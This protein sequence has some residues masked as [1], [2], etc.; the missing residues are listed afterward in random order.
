MHKKIQIHND[1]AC[2]R[3]R[4][5]RSSYVFRRP[6]R[7][8][9][10]S[11][12]SFVVRPSSFVVRRSSCVVR[13]SSFVVRRRRSSFVVRRSKQ[14]GRTNERTKERYFI[15]KYMVLVHMFS[16][17]VQLQL[18]LIVHCI[19]TSTD[20][21]VW[22]SSVRSFVRCQHNNIHQQQRRRRRRRRRRTTNDER[23]QKQQRRSQRW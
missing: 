21:F 2:R 9:L 17:L 11:S 19:R 14:N 15:T 23:P 7:F 4:P 1:P 6:H 12:A 3:P 13:R 10:S 20:C 8:H 18:V 16:T 22:F 5:H